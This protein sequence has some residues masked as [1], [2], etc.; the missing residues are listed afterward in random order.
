MKAF[1]KI[2]GFTALVAGLTPYKVDKN[3]ETG[4][5][6]YQ[7]LLWR[8]TSTS[9]EDGKKR[10]IGINLG[11]GTLTAKIIDAVE[12]QKEAHLFSDE[13]SV[14]YTVDDMEEDA[15]TAAG[16]ADE[17][18]EEKASEAE[19][20]AAAAE[21]AA[22]KAEEAAQAYEKAAEKAEEAAEAYEEAA[23]EAEEAAEASEE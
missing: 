14:E 15:E 3:E 20:A 5:N 11:E 13:L 9:G 1:L 19:E 21:E 22:E 12:K 2:L 17:T 23:E 6:S 8:I 16:E 4:E 7:A 18:A 10:D